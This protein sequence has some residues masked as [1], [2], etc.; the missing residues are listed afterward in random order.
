L[1]RIAGDLFL[2]ELGVPGIHFILF[3]VNRGESVVLDQVLGK[4]D[5]VFEVVALP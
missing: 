1:G 3:D 2:T 5:R 4:D